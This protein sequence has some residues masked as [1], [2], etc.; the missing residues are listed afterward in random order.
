MPATAFV[1]DVRIVASNVNHAYLRILNLIN[2]I[3]VDRSQR[4]DFI[5]TEHRKTKSL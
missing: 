4:V 5:G 3:F 2:D 1:H